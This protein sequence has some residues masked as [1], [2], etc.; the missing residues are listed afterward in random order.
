MNLLTKASKTIRTPEKLIKPSYDFEN[1]VSELDKLN[2]DKSINNLNY[3]NQ[4]IISS[5][6]EKNK[7]QSFHSIGI[8]CSG[9][10]NMYNEINF[11]DKSQQIFPD[12]FKYNDVGTTY[13][14]KEYL[15]QDASMQASPIT[16][17]IDVIS[18][19]G[20]KFTQV[21]FELQSPTKNRE[22]QML[23]QINQG[24]QTLNIFM[25]EKF[26]QME[27]FSSPEM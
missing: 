9:E 22:I 1:C 23:P 24:S 21:D 14:C 26:T 6:S 8:G 7:K 19:T 5:T 20:H 2:H 13:S 15:F 27:P 10:D 11:S 25:H 3:L 17:N 4:K 16:S 12:E 18:D